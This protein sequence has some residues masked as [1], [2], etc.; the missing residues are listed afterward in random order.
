M[1]A[2]VVS[3]QF[4]GVPRPAGVL[5][6]AHGVDVIRERETI[7]GRA[8]AIGYAL[9]VD[10][11]PNAVN[12]ELAKLQA[13]TAADIQRVARKYLADDRR[14]QAG[15][16]PNVQFLVAVDCSLDVGELSRWSGPRAPDGRIV[17]LTRD[18]C[19]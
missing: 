16:C 1:Y 10:G 4:N 7:D 19:R 5:L 17:S 6:S 18:P 9:R 14:I 12:T 8:S 2:E 11:D 15:S 13:V 3:N